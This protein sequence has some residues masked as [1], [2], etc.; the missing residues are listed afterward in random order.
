MVVQEMISHK[1]GKK[2]KGPEIDAAKE[3]E[4][5]GIRHFC[6]QG[7]NADRAEPPC[8]SLTNYIIF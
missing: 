7:M 4:S 5:P 3:R 6:H 8:K 1:G 2:E